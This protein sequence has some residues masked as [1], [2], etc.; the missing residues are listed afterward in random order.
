[1]SSFNTGAGRMSRRRGVAHHLDLSIT[2]RAFDMT[3]DAGRVTLAA[4]VN[5]RGPLSFKWVQ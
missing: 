5:D 3:L 2:R 4:G 1:M